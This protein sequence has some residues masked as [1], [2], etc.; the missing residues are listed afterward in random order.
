M[1]CFL[2]V[3]LF[4]YEHVQELVPILLPVTISILTGPVAQLD[5]FSSETQGT[6]VKISKE[7]VTSSLQYPTHLLKLEKR[8]NTNLENM[9]YILHVIINSVSETIPTSPLTHILPCNPNIPYVI[10]RILWGIHLCMCV[11]A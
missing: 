8:R 9:L 2:F 11:H 10:P 4:F 3:C 6:K 7:L 1:V 5:L